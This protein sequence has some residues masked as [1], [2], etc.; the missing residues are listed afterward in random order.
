MP[1]LLSGEQTQKLWDED[2]VYNM[3]PQHWVQ[4][5]PLL[6]KWERGPLTPQAEV[7]AHAFKR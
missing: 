7:L 6:K 2:S 4:Q 3:G 1:H 5:I